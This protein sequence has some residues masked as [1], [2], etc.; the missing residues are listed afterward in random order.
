MGHRLV[1]FLIL[2]VPLVLMIV[3]N[4]LF[5]NSELENPHQSHGLETINPGTPSK[6]SCT[7][8]CHDDTSFCK[9]HHV[10]FNAAYFTY[11]DPLYFGMIRV[12]K[13]FGDY[14]LANILLLVLFFPLLIYGLLI[15]SL[16]IQRRITSLK[17][18]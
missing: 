11:T 13:G 17:K 18:S 10:K 1:N 8:A 5:R 7:W 2:V 12:L 6:E 16:S 3:I 14:G 15:R 4:E 9:T